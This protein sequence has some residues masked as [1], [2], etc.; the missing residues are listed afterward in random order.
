MNI[1]NKIFLAFVLAPK[2]LYSQWGIHVP[3]LT[4]ILT[5][6]LIMDDRRPNTIQATKQHRDKN[7]EISNATLGTMLMSLLMGLSFLLAFSLGDDYVTQ[8]TVYFTLFITLLCMSLVSDFTS[9][10]IDIR[11]TNIILPKP[12]NDRT[13]VVARLLHIFIHICKITIPMCL[14]GFVYLVVT[15]GIVAGLL[16]LI[17]AFFAVLLAIFLINA[18]YIFILRITT[19]EKFKNIISYF[20]IVFAILIYA[21]YQV[22]PRM[23]DEITVKGLDVSDNQWLMIAPPFWFACSFNT[24]LT[25]QGS[26]VEWVAAFMAFVVPVA[27]IYVVIKYLAP[28]FN[29]KLAMISG[30][31][32]AS[33]SRSSGTEWQKGVAERLAGWMTTNKVEYTG[34]LFTWKMM[35]R[36]RDFKVRVYPSA[37]YFVVILFMIFF[38]NKGNMDAGP[39]GFLFSFK[40]MIAIYLSSMIVTTAMSQMVYSD[41]YNASWVFLIAPVRQPGQIISGALKATLF[42]FAFW[43]MVFS[44]IAGLW[45]AGPAVLPNLLLAFCNQ[46]LITYAIALIGFKRLPFSQPLGVA[47]KSGQFVRGFAMVFISML[48]GGVHY[49]IYQNAVAVGVF[50]FISLLILGGLMYSI[51]K[52]AWE[53]VENPE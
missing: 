2:N 9:V 28:A 41:K 51:R 26:P 4:S 45:L 17:I 23:M 29:Q 38:R 52:I 43:L 16:L 44:L 12:V 3:H 7:K 24:L 15:A 33:P 42:Q 48:T 31:E 37:G 49:L 40:P 50:L 5:T 30:G 18:V 13:V 35:A 39:D 20:Q 14:P 1:F 36:S 53:E 46:L 11:D 21:S 47:Q 25:W 34:F 27:S 6:K 32:T 22:L 8:L 19:P 10:L